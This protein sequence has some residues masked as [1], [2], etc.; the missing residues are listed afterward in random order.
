M[1][2]LIYIVSPYSHAND[3]VR[4]ENFRKVSKIAADLCAS[5]IVALSPI[6]YGHTLLSFQQMPDDWQFWKNFCLTLLEKCDGLLVVQMKGWD[7][8]RGVHAEIEFA[9]RTGIKISW[10][11]VYD[12]PLDADI[13]DDIYTVAEWKEAVELGAFKNWDGSGYWVKDGMKSSAEVFSSDPEDATHVV[14]YNK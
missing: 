3:E 10:L 1:A 2:K 9:K 11:R 13:D 7:F 5:G 4:E 6:T 14:W 12:D 8:S